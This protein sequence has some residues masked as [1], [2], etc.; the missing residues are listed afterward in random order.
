MLGN[1]LYYAAC[2]EFERIKAGGGEAR[3][4]VPGPEGHRKAEAHKSGKCKANG[5][6]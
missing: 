5:C 4:C 3:A 2:L 1:V 6:N